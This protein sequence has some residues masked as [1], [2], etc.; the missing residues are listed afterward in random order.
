MHGN[1]QNSHESVN[2]VVWSRMFLQTEKLS[3]GTC[4]IVASFNES[5]IAKYE[6]LD[7]QRGT[8]QRRTPGL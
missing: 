1:I 5:D 2:N 7:C 8:A 3:I 4:D 6:T